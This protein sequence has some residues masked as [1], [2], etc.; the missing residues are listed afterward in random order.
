MEFNN[1]LFILRKEFFGGLL[2]NKSNLTRYEIN[3]YDAYFL[4]I[5]SKGSYEVSEVVQC[6]EEHFSIDYYPNVEKFI[7]MG[8][9][10][11]GE[12]SYKIKK[13]H[14]P[15]Y[16]ENC[17][18][19]KYL[20]YPFEISIYPSLQCNLK[21]SFC[22]LGDKLNKRYAEKSATQWFDLIKQATQDGCLSISILGGEPLLYYDIFKL[23]NYLENAKIRTSMT[24]NGLC[25]N[26]KMINFIQTSQYVTPIFSIQ[27]LGLF[28]RDVMGRNHNIQRWV[29]TVTEI[30][31]YKKVRIN[32]VYLGQSIDD[33][34]SIVDFCYKNNVEKYSLAYQYDINSDWTSFKALIDVQDELE[35]YIRMSQYD[36]LN[37]CVEGC[38]I[39]STY[40]NL[41]G[42]IV[43]SEYQKL[44][45]GCEAGNSRLE[46]LPNGDSFPCISFLDKDLSCGNVFDSSIKKVWD[47]SALL[48]EIR[49]GKTEDE[50][51]LKCSLVHFCNGGCPMVNL[52]KNQKMFGE[53]DPRC[54]IRKER[55]G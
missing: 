37:F 24:S 41:D 50:K 12:K 17:D 11:E 23:V 46:I 45:Y 47:D 43:T 33:L 14:L 6:I 2:V 49:Y 4:E 18:K 19:P 30:S 3:K 26:K 40:K 31:K 44:T 13:E 55:K 53:G 25:W 38:M 16:V 5:L 28:N 42:S 48:S 51:C 32:T 8:V 29:S 34:K 52:S 15:I 10:L 9:L 54:L 22:F 35:R 1:K 27:S 7:E 39:Y 20:S 21:C 36:N